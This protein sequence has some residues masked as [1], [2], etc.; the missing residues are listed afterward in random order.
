MKSRAALALVAFAQVLILAFA[1]CGSGNAM[2]TTE[3]PTIVTQINAAAAPPTSSTVI[4]PTATT[5][6]PVATTQPRTTTQPSTTS[7][8]P[9]ST[10]AT[11]PPTSPLTVKFLSELP[12]PLELTHVQDWIG[13]C[14]SCHAAGASNPFPLPSM[15][16]DVDFKTGIYTVVSGSTA[17]HTGRTVEQCT[18]AGCHLPSESCH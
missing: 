6:A 7:V 1:G 8:S 5:S 2:N 17:D 11:T 18:Q 10:I 13:I 4:P 12:R 14:L 3:V 16:D 9:A 15:W